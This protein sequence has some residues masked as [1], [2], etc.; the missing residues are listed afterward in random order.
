MHL[1]MCQL[2]PGSGHLAAI[3]LRQHR[4]ATIAIPEA[5]YTRLLRGSQSSPPHGG[6]LPRPPH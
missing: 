4:P 6:G 2:W 5:L 1:G 3:T